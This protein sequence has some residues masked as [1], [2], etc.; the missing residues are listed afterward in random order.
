[1]FNPK[2]NTSI[3][4]IWANQMSVLTEGY[5]LSPVGAGLEAHGSSRWMQVDSG[6]WLRL[7]RAGMMDV[8]RVVHA[9]VA[10]AIICDVGASERRFAA[11]AAYGLLAPALEAVV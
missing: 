9:V 1:M 2:E 8:I 6:A 5:R 4:A 10:S 11:L 7:Q 3:T